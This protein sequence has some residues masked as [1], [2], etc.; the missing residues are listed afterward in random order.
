MS[1]ALKLVLGL[2]ALSLLPGALLAITSFTRIAIVLSFVRRAIGTQTLPPNQTLIG[3]SLFLTLF[4]MWPVLQKVNTQ[5][6]EP[7]REGT[8]GMREGFDRAAAAFRDFMVPRTRERDLALFVEISGA[9]PPATP[10]DVPMLVAVP[11]YV[12]SELRTAFE[13]GLVIF[14]PFVVIDLVV[15]AILLALGMMMLPPALVSAPVKLLLFVLVDG[16]HLVVRSLVESV[17]P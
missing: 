16:W 10:Q 1:A 3:L 2:T 12:I 11:A 15:S 7:V 4:T 6:V 17:A 5:A 14:V 8:I 9:E 13:M